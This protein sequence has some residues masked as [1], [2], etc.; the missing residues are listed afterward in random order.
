MR[1]SCCFLFIMLPILLLGV[2][3]S[4]TKNLGDIRMG[5]GI[6]KK[7]PLYKPFRLPVTPLATPSI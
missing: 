7:Y 5:K 2:I 3:L 1:L 4:V 6:F